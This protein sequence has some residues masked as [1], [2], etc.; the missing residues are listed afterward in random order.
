M[1]Q[2]E[3]VNYVMSRAPI[4]DQAD[5]EGHVSIIRSMYRRG[6]TAGDAIVHCLLS[7][8]CGFTGT[9]KEACDM[10]AWIDSLY[11]M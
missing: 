9:E 3:F 4:L 5:L 7:E 11:P 2:D 8:E 10:M 6:F 1:T